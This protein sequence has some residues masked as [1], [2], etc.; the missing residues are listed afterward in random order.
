VDGWVLKV[1]LCGEWEECRFAT[2]AEALAAFIALTVDYSAK[3]E[4]AVLLS[5]KNRP[6][7]V[8][9]I[10]ENEGTRSQYVN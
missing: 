2:R 7:S 5:P 8:L 3:L 10:P 6:D 1:E 4:R 9:S